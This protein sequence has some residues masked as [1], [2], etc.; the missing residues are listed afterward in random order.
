MET[1]PEIKV[2][3]V[4]DREDNLFSMST[5][6]ERDGYVIRTARSGREALKI[7]LKEHDFTLILLDVQMPDLSGYETASLIYERDKLKHIPVIFVTAH[8]YSDEYVYKGYQ[9]G[10]VDYIYKPINPELLRAK[11]NVFAELYRKT[12]LLVAHEKQLREMN[13]ELE[14]RVR[15]RTEE[16]TDKNV[17]LERANFE[18]KKVNNDLDSFVYAASHDL[19]A[20]VSNIEGLLASLTDFFS[21]DMLEDDNVKMIIGMINESISR[22]KVTIHDLTEVTK[23]QKSIDEDVNTIDILDVIEDVKVGIRDM[24]ENTG[25]ILHIVHHGDTKVSFSRKNLKSVLYNLISNA[26]KYRSSERVPEVEINI[27][28]VEEYIIISVSDNGLGFNPNDK[29]KIFTMFKRLHD[30]VEGTGIGLYIV[31]KIVENCGGRIEV[32]SEQGKGTT[33]SVFIRVNPE[34]VLI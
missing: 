8:S 28:R 14:D 9:A 16:L 21:A 24:I 17:E 11:V 26:I 13:N 29:E 22:F 34:I 10:A 33:F 19:K 15:Q 32:D 6:L 7:L 4:D 5:V 12:H 23:I 18:L 3:L 27:G 20:P 25:A 2:L 1:K 30:H 31:K